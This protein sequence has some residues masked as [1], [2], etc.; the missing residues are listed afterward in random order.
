MV[1]QT[2]RAKKMLNLL[3]RLVKQEYLYTDEKI[4]EVKSQ[5]RILEEEISNIESKQSKGF[6]K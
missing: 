1:I 4:R 6:G 3:K 2:S 5:I